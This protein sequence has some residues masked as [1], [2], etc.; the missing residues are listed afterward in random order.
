MDPHAGQE[1]H[2]CGSGFLLAHHALAACQAGSAG[3]RYVRQGAIAT[4]RLH[5]GERD[6]RRGTGGRRWR[7]NAWPARPERPGRLPEDAGDWPA[8]TELLALPE[9]AAAARA[10]EFVCGSST[11]A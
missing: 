2:G 5:A 3:S 9:P 10:Q 6:G 7:A 11:R 8:L 4:C 1:V